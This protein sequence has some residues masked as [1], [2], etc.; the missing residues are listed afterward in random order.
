MQSFRYAK[1]LIQLSLSLS[2]YMY[3]HDTEFYFSFFLKKI[4]KENKNWVPKIYTTLK[5]GSLDLILGQIGRHEQDMQ[6]RA[7]QPGMAATF[8]FCFLPPSRGRGAHGPADMCVCVCVC[9]CVIF[10]KVS[11]QV[12]LLYQVSI[13]RTFR[14]CVPL[15]ALEFVGPTSSISATKPL[16]S[17]E[18]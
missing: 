16:A 3:L 15:Q 18:P 9:V 8:G 1:L 7:L 14:G 13:Q 5:K 12:Y 17:A 6:A 10:S 4:E 11:A 2:Q